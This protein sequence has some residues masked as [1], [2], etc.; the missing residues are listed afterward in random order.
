M[1]NYNILLMLFVVFCNQ[2]EASYFKG[3][4]KPVAASCAVMS[5]NILTPCADDQSKRD[6]NNAAVKP[7]KITPQCNCSKYINSDIC[8]QVTDELKKQTINFPDDFMQEELV[9][10]SD[11]IEGLAYEQL[12]S[13]GQRV[14]Y[15]QREF[16]GYKLSD[17]FDFNLIARHVSSIC[18]FDCAEFIS[19]IHE[20]ARQGK[21]DIITMHHLHKTLVWMHIRAK[22]RIEL[23][24]LYPGF[25]VKTLDLIIYLDEILMS[26][27][28][29]LYP[30]RKLQT[31]Y[32]EA[33]HAL[34]IA[35]R[36]CGV[37]LA[38]FSL[39]R[40]DEGFNIAQSQYLLP[41]S[42]L[43]VSAEHD[44]KLAQSK[45]KIMLFLAGGI[46]VQLLEGKKLSYKD[47]A[48]SVKKYGMGSSDEVGTDWWY[49][50][51]TA[52]DY[53]LKKDFELVSRYQEDL[54]PYAMPSK[55]KLLADMNILIEECYEDAYRILHANKD[56]LDIIVTETLNKGVTSGDEI[57]KLAGVPRPKYYFELT[58]ME[59]MQR[60]FIRCL[61]WTYKRMSFYERNHPQI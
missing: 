38:Q 8:K 6:A 22:D 46:G 19:K 61:A 56:T 24:S 13:H 23:N 16:Q 29:W 1:K 17:D 15:L 30:S 14:A 60:D 9:D 7:K 48:T 31:A 39:H 52:L 42:L 53:C 37:V 25:D 4:K 59:T 57:Y 34:M 20:F 51:S 10:D 32:H 54:E 28:S 47:F 21:S 27:L 3:L 2:L 33:G 43:D 36:P 18:S 12:V 58:P 49:I 45:K 5:R 35:L 11:S 55:E 44:D 50:C 41:Q 40:Q 26:V